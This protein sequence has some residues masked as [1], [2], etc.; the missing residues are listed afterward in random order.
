M[1]DAFCD[2]SVYKPVYYES[3]SFIVFLDIRPLLPGHSL[4]A[5]KR[6]MLYF[7]ELSDRELLE[8]REVMDH[9]L[10]RLLEA[11]GADSYNISVN[12]GDHAG[13]V[14]KHLHV[15]VVPRSATDP[16]QGRIVTF[17]SLLQGERRKYA[18]DVGKELE[19][20][21]KIFRYKGKGTRKQV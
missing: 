10:P 6:H 8:L 12:A 9:V 3:E 1:Q 15:H 20:L 19:R 21:R 17:Y 13:M 16:M 2:G 11:Y 4:I 7:T 5:P 18:R 14:V